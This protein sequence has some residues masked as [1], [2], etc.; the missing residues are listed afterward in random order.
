MKGLWLVAAIWVCGVGCKSATMEEVIL[1]NYVLT[2]G[3][4]V[5]TEEEEIDVVPFDEKMQA[6]T[7]K[8]S[9]HFAKDIELEISIRKNLKEIGYEF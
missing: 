8:L 5:G 7:A 3:R 1:N 2:P 9:T 6:L 4:Y